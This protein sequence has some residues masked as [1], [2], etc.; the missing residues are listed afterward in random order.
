MVGYRRPGAPGITGGFGWSVDAERREIEIRI[1]RD[2]LD[3]A[4]AARA[5]VVAMTLDENAGR[6]LDVLG[7]RR[8]AE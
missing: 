6:V 7:G 3:P 4:R 5:W 1:P 8:P 2:I